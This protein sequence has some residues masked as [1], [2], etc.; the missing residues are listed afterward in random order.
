MLSIIALLCGCVD[1]DDSTKAINASIKLTMP[2]EFVNGVDFANH[3]I[4]LTNSNGAKFTVQTDAQGVAQFNNLV[5]DVYDIST[6]WHLTSEQYSQLTGDDVVSDGAVVTGVAMA[7]TLTMDGAEIKLVTNVSILRS[8]VISKIYYAASKDN[9]NKNYQ[10][11]KYLELYNQSADTIDVAGYYLGLVESNSTP[12]YTIDITPDSV[13]MKQIF[14]IPADKPVK[15]AP[16]EAIV[17]CNSAIDHTKNGASEQNLLSADFEAKDNATKNA[18]ENN[19][20]VPALEPAY[21]NTATLTYMNLVQSG[22]CSLVLFKSTPEEVDA[23]P[24]VYAYGKVSGTRFKQIPVSVVI[25]GVDV[26][27]YKATGI[28]IT[29]KR[30]PASLDAGFT[31]I[32]S[33][34]GYNGQV[35]YR[36]VS[37]TT[38]DGRK[39]LLD[40]NNSTADFQIGSNA[41]INLREY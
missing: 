22:T 40:T 29:G 30:L 28:D 36:K 2:E 13:Y 39:I 19:P 6:S 11:G 7:Q 5:P 16:G 24:V 32:E 1:Y 4:T 41:D 33:A 9:N 26:L 31:N 25:D 8:M 34:S 21:L 35:I 12:A 18:H 3:E 23:W 15:V 38:A 20:D 14:R 17:L 10:Y 27:K 37:R